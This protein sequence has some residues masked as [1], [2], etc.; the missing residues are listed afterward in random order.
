MQSTM[1]EHL[2]PGEVRTDQMDIYEGDRNDIAAMVRIT[3]GEL[4]YCPVMRL[5]PGWTDCILSE[6]CGHPVVSRNFRFFMAVDPT[7]VPYAYDF[8]S[9]RGF[10]HP[11][12]WGQE[13]PKDRVMGCAIFYPTLRL[14]AGRPLPNTDPFHH[15]PQKLPCRVCMGIL[16]F[17]CVAN[18]PLSRRAMYLDNIVVRKK[19]QRKGVAK[20]LMSAV[21]PSPLFTPLP[22]VLV[23]LGRASAPRDGCRYGPLRLI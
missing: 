13:D 20:A 23:D 21:A 1:A 8:L 6:A 4:L 22:A 18:P 7:M 14:D 15:A 16:A 9:A 2:G 17:I 12:G 11:C 10:P 19:H 5:N 3:C